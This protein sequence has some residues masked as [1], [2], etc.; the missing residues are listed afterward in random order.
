MAGKNNVF[1]HEI[2]IVLSGGQQRE[3]EAAFEVG[4]QAYNAL[5]SETLRRLE[6]LRE[7][8]AYQS[9]RR[10]PRS[11]GRT[12]R[13][14]ELRRRHG[15]RQFDL[16]HWNALK[17]TPSWLSEHLD[18]H[19]I[20]AL[21]ERAFKA[22]EEHELGRRGRPRFKGRNQLDSLESQSNDQG[23][24]YANGQVVWKDRRY[25]LRLDLSDPYTEYALATPI[26]RVRI[27]RRRIK[28]KTRYWAQLICAGNPFQPGDLERSQGRVGIDPGPRFF[29]LVSSEAAARVDLGAP[30]GRD[31]RL[32]RKLGRS[33]ARKR[34]IGSPAKAGP[35]GWRSKRYVLESGRLSDLYRRNAA[36]RRN[37]HGRLANTVLCLGDQIYVE[38]NGFKAFQRSFGRSVAIASPGAFVAL[39]TRK[40]ANAGVLISEVPTGLRLSQIC[41]R[42]GSIQKKP[43]SQRIH[44]CECGIDPIQRDIYSAWLVT[45]AG[46]DRR[47]SCWS[48]DADQA[49]R[50]WSGARQRLLA[51]SSEISVEDF[52][53]AAESQAASGRISAPSLS[54]GTEQLVKTARAKRGEVRDVV[55]VIARA[56]KSC[57]GREPIAASGQMSPDAA[58]V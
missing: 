37:L 20:R 15:L 40:A 31:G 56:R 10:I 29:A 58:M 53:S 6:L 9:A 4:R 8:R 52:C 43:L 11:K 49:R 35:R 16:Y 21:A 55:A 57:A 51:A 27:V 2:P 33:L 18:S 24:R 41:H 7:S 3:L 26:R 50:A 38:R 19:T 1:I 39:L 34:R 46:Y 28:E 36:R 5:L 17:L 32:A 12:L 54:L 45:F 47:R 30:L 23:I 14:R 42:C 13:L 48:L 44:T 25:A 22:I